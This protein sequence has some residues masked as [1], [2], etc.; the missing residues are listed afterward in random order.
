MNQFLQ[1]T[2]LI[3]FIMVVIRIYFI[4]QFHINFIR[5]VLYTLMNFHFLNFIKLILM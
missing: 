3:F 5:L 2:Q 4:N 1:V